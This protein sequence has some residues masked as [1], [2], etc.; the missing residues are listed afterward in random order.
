MIEEIAEQLSERS[1]NA[2]KSHHFDILKAT[3]EDIFRIV[4]MGS[5]SL[6]TSFR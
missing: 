2:Y 4:V 3:L 6:S 1:A 5:S